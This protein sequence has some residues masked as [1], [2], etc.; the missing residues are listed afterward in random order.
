MVVGKTGS[1]LST[2]DRNP[3]TRVSFVA[4]SSNYS[5]EIGEIATSYTGVVILFSWMK[6]R[7]VTLILR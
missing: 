4:A 7:P 6:S 1:T 2:V 3:N 5:Y